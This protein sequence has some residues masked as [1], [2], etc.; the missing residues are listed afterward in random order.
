MAFPA[1]NLEGRTSTRS[2][3]RPISD[4]SHGDEG[5]DFAFCGFTGGAFS[6][7]PLFYLF[8][9]GVKLISAMG[10]PLFKTS[11]GDGFDILGEWEVVIK[12]ELWEASGGQVLIR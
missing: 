6:D 3:D 4:S 7:H 9:R 5:D 2:M 8:E 11:E 1:F 10:K 12:S